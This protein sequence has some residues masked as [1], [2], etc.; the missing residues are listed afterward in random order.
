MLKK[1]LYQSILKE[2][3]GLGGGVETFQQ[4]PL[5]PKVSVLRISNGKNRMVKWR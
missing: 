1:S 5:S 4:G 3:P 2:H